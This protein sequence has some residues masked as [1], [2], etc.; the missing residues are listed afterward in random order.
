MRK[1]VIVAAAVIGVGVALK[2]LAP[3]R[4]PR[5]VE[6]TPAQ[7]PA[8]VAEGPPEIIDAARQEIE[9][10]GDETNEG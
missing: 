8:P 5:R 1:L 2:I 3:K 9:Y 6:Q 7:T 10:P 4:A